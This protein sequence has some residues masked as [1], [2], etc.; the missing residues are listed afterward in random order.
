[1]WPTI[2]LGQEKGQLR[3]R[4]GS[5]SSCIGVLGTLEADSVS[6]PIGRGWRSAESLVGCDIAVIFFGHVVREMRWAFWTS[7]R[8]LADGRRIW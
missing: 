7:G 6:A 3:S 5:V 1:M 2:F 8:S 4:I